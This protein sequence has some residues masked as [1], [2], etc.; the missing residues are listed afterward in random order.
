MGGI[1]TTIMPTSPAGPGSGH[2]GPGTGPE[3]EAPLRQQGPH[4]RPGDHDPCRRLHPSRHP[5]AQCAAAP[6]NAGLSHSERLLLRTK[7]PRAQRIGCCVGSGEGK[8]ALRCTSFPHFVVFISQNSYTVR[9]PNPTELKS[10]HINFPSRAL[11]PQTRATP[12]APLRPRRMLADPM[13]SSEAVFEMRG[14]R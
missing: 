2:R 7:L 5:G 1:P 12:I 10:D 4:R 6:A 13:D 9:V 14:V 11:T 8:S 3:R